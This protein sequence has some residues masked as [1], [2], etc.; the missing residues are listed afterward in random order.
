MSV[1]NT[2]RRKHRPTH[3]GEMLREDF[4]PDYDLTVAGLA[5]ATAVS[6]Q[7]VHGLLQNRRGVS[8]EIKDDIARMFEMSAISVGLVVD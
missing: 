5:E 3:P 7:S 1:P 2:R 6:R 8:P 4:L